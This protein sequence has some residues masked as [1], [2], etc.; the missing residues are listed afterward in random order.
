VHHCRFPL[1]RKCD[2]R[3]YGILHSLEDETSRLPQNISNKIL[4]HAVQK[5]V[6]LINRSIVL[7][8]VATLKNVFK[9]NS[10]QQKQQVLLQNVN[11]YQT[12]WYHIPGDTTALSP[13]LLPTQAQHILFRAQDNKDQKPLTL[14]GLH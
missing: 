5:C 3:S 7:N 2:L 14:S 13:Q 11:F 10:S 9:V 12:T 1:Q 8:T 4:F 6:D